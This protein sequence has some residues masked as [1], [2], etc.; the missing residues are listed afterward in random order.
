[1]LEFSD[2][3]LRSKA[4]KMVELDESQARI[5]H[6][7]MFVSKD[8]NYLKKFC[9]MVSMLLIGKDDDNICLRIEKHSHPDVLFY[10]ENSN[11]VVDDISEIIE[12]SQ[13]TPFEADKKIF[14]LLGSENMNEASQN[15]LLKTIEEPPTNTYFILGA[16]NTSRTLQTI[17]SRVKLIELDELSSEDIETMLKKAGIEASKAIVYASSANGDATFAE[18]L[19]TDDGFIDFFN[20]V[21]ACFYEINGSRDVLKFSN[22]FTAKTV[23]KSEFID[24]FLLISRDLGMI[25]SGQSE[26]VNFKNLLPKLKVVANTLNLEAVSELIK[27][28]VSAKEKLFFNVNGTSVVDEILFKLAEV[29][30]KCRRS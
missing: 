11:I 16:K 17:L 14:V 2:F 9:E 27:A 13:V 24:L 22:K 4:Y 23:D 8:E 6:A 15:K 30:V 10:G 5:C 25:I 12:K 7:Y 29:K 26:L 1:M 20:S 19:A 21:A 18:K 28:C 3:I